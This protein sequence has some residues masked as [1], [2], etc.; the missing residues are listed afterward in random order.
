LAKGIAVLGGKGNWFDISRGELEKFGRRGRKV[1]RRGIV[2]AKERII[3]II[4]G[5]AKMLGISLAKE[6]FLGIIM[7]KVDRFGISGR[8]SNFCWQKE[9]KI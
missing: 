5:K 6:E 9:G 8:R 7:R 3:G 2:V 1:R 4:S